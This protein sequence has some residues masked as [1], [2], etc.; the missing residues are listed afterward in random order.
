M[1]L[2]F[3]IPVNRVMNEEVISIAP[4]CSLAEADQI[5]REARIRHLPVVDE[6]N[7][8]VG[9]LSNRNMLIAHFSSKDQ[10]GRRVAAHIMSRDLIT[11]SPKTCLCVV[12]ELLFENKIGCAPV[13]DKK[14]HL[15]GI[16]T[17]SDF[18]RITYTGHRCEDADAA[19]PSE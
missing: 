8:L 9:L 13:V 7:R 17:E 11:V 10:D 3:C 4:T 1:G 5:L 14:G 12:G 18:V 16:I 2:S 19:L 15:L 6:G